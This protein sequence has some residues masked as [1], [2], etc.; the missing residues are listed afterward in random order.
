MIFLQIANK[1]FKYVSYEGLEDCYYTA[2]KLENVNNNVS[3]DKIIAENEKMDKNQADTFFSE[4]NFENINNF[5][6]FSQ[7]NTT[8]ECDSLT[9]ELNNNF[10]TVQML[11]SDSAKEVFSNLVLVLKEK[12]NSLRKSKALNF[13]LAKISF[14]LKSNFTNMKLFLDFLFKEEIGKL[15]I[16]NIYINNFF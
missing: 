2:E 11:K 7:G 5:P 15:Y 10:K 12:G 8:K 4:E 6:L 16:Y 13:I 1:K 3:L 9:N 14:Y